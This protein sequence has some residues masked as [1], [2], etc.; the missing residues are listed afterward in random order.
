MNHKAFNSKIVITIIFV[1]DKNKVLYFEKVWYDISYQD[2][3]Q[4]LNESYCVLRQFAYFTEFE[5]V[6]RW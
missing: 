3:Q 4:F 5:I 6:E 1:K 2:I